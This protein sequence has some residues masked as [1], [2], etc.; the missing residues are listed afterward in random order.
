MAIWSDNK[1]NW[2][3][4]VGSFDSAGSNLGLEDMEYL[5]LEMFLFVDMNSLIMKYWCGVLVDL[6]KWE[7]NFLLVF[8]GD[9]YIVLVWLA[10]DYIC[11]LKGL[12]RWIIGML[13]WI[14]FEKIGDFLMFLISW[15]GIFQMCFM[16]AFHFRNFVGGYCICI[17]MLWL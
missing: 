6:E 4:I 7:E 5:N 2:R 14:I 1:G 15:V 3:C 10:W 8:M 16:F 12:R 13:S 17:I 11:T 9:G